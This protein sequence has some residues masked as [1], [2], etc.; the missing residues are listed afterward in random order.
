MYVVCRATHGGVDDFEL[1]TTKRKAKQLFDSFLRDP[2][3]SAACIGN[4]FEAT[5]PH[6]TEKRPE[7]N[8]I[9]SPVH[10][11]PDRGCAVWIDGKALFGCPMY[12]D[13]RLDFDC[14]YQISAPEN[15]AFL[16]SVNHA[17]GTNYR[18][19]QFSGR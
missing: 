5:E 10:L 11:M 14:F 16:D 17:L 18:L 8:P 13:G 2:E 3:T 7:D 12:E 4:V 6:W 1:Q 19:E 9:P 15:Q